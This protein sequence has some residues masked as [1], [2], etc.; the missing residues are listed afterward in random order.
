VFPIAFE[1]KCL[2]GARSLATPTLRIISQL[3]MGSPDKVFTVDL[4]AV[5]VYAEAADLYGDAVRET[6][7]QLASAIEIKG[8]AAAILATGNT[9]I[10]FLKQLAELGGVDWSKVTLFH[11]DEYLG[12]AGD[13]PASF[14]R[15]MKERVEAL[16]KPQAFHYLQGDS[17]EPI[18][19]CERYEALL[20]AQPIDLCMLGL[21]ENGHLAFNDPHVANFEDKRAV[22]IVSLDETCRHQQ[23][24]QGHFPDIQNMPQYALTITIPTL[25]SAEKVLCMALDERKQS[26]VKRLLRGP[27]S[28]D[29]PATALRRC[30]NATLLLDA[31]AAANV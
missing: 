8:A 2:R 6:Q 29:C 1:G 18:R 7:A 31:A 28:H 15:Y 12:I 9:Q 19:E 4:L 20:R 10:D 14:R 5:R 21:G 26:P 25:L 23:V 30:E 22:K 11:M 13:H 17:D 24:K 3:N 16:L 27:I